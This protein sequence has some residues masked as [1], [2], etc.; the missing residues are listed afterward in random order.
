M[1]NSAIS[2]RSS[3]NSSRQNGSH[4][5]HIVQSGESR[6]IGPTQSTLTNKTTSQNVPCSRSFLKG[7]YVSMK[8]QVI[9]ADV[10]EKLMNIQDRYSSRW[11]ISSNRDQN[12]GLGSQYST[13]FLHRRQSEPRRSNSCKTRQILLSRFIPC[14]ATNCYSIQEKLKANDNRMVTLA[15]RS[16]PNHGHINNRAVVRMT[17]S[18]MLTKTGKAA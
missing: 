2:A 3:R 1:I 9:N 4:G 5:V 14:S 17:T 18:R 6:T 8:Y 15:L 7:S 12:Y 16:R 11:V 13:R 10:R